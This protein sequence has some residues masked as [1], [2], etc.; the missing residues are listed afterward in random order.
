FGVLIILATLISASA[1]ELESS[2]WARAW[3][4]WSSGSFGSR[5]FS[6]PAV[7]PGTAPSPTPG[8]T[9][10]PRLG[11]PGMGISRSSFWSGFAGGVAGWFIGNLLFGGRAYAGPMGYGGGLGLLDL[12]MIGALIY[13]GYRYFVRRKGEK[14]SHYEEKRGDNYAQYGAPYYGGSRQPY[15]S[16]LNEVERGLEEI[17]RFD[18]SFNTESFLETVEDLFFRI[19]AAWINRSLDG[20]E[21]M[22]T[23]EMGE[24]FSGEFARM[25]HEHIINRLENI[26]VREVEPAEVWQESGRDF[27]AVLFTASLLDYTVDDKTG[28]LV[29]GDRLN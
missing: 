9:P 27:I 15:I 4:E 14:S 29:K 25:K 20:V 21:N 23:T 7:P 19:Q 2:A 17:R 13:F 16:E 1:L 3:G 26:A 28:K 8:V 18:P 24:Y 11:P 12:L 5:S 22:L 10:N 6:V